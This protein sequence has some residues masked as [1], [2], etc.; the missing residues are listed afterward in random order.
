MWQI[1]YWKTKL[2]SNSA[3]SLLII[4]FFIY[5]IFS[6]DF[7]KTSLILQPFDVEVWKYSF[8]FFFGYAIPSAIQLIFYFL[9]YDLFVTNILHIALISTTS[10]HS[11]TTLILKRIN[12][13]I[14]MVRRW[15]SEI[16]KLIVYISFYKNE[17]TKYLFYF[18]LNLIYSLF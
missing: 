3:I 15:T 9:R 5:V 16:F 7:S 13:I 2:K 8:P 6:N 12:L 18:V 10:L 14:S 11:I 17:W 1:I 4:F